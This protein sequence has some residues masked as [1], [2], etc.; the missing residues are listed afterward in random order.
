MRTRH[1]VGSGVNAGGDLPRIELQQ[2]FISSVA[3]Q[4]Q[5]QGLFS[6]ISGMLNVAKIATKA[7]TVDDGLKSVSNLLHLAR[8]L[9]ALKS[10][11]INLITLPSTMDTY[12]G[13][14]AHMMAVQPQDDLL[15]QM[16][17]TG[18]L[19]H[20][21]L[22][23]EAYGKIKVDVVNGAGVHGL[24]SH[25]AAA[26]RKLGF[27]VTRIGD[28]TATSTT[29]VSFAGE[30]QAEAAYT[31]MTA[32]KSFPAGQD[33]LNEPASQIGAPGV[34]T[35]VLGTDFAGV[36]PLAPAGPVKKHAKKKTGSARSAAAGSTPA[37]SPS[38][39]VQSRNAG[40]SICSG[41]PPAYTPGSQGPP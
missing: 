8:S 37:G 27:V 3:Q 35:L 15:Y 24:A 11:D 12:P 10:K 19:W 9:T 4:V 21:R 14:S 5:H 29:T 22:P 13:L 39:G 2:A 17:R 7:L 1:G 28:T 41:L 6:N 25:T 30:S 34:I 32:L 33:T 20:G 16:V 38:G 26:L 18:Q 23:T 31:L 40:A 36:R